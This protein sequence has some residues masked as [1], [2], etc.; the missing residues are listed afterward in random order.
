M[1]RRCRRSC[2]TTSG[3]VEREVIPTTRS[4]SSSDGSGRGEHE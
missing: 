3:N 4:G 2:Y 1:C